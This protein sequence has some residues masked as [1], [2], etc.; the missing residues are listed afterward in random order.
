MYS[1]KGLLNSSLVGRNT[2]VSCMYCVMSAAATAAGFVQQR[3]LGQS[4]DWS[5]KDQCCRQ[6]DAEYGCRQTTAAC[7][8]TCWSSASADDAAVCTAD[9]RCTAAAPAQ[10]PL[11]ASA[12]CK[13]CAPSASVLELTNYAS[14]QQ[15]LSRCKLLQAA[16]CL[17]IET[18]LQEQGRQGGDP[19]LDMH[20]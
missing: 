9:C 11:P 18:L 3:L 15:L 12:L 20:A 4:T 10:A 16:C 13:L 8:S 6:A 7:Q 1:L 14:F 5:T 17:L 19:S 2:G